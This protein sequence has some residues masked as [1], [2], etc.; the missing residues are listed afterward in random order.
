M[1]NLCSLCVLSCAY[2]LQKNL[3][4]FLCTDYA[5]SSR[6]SKKLKVKHSFKEYD[7]STEILLLSEL[8]N[9]CK[10]VFKIEVLTS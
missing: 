6:V 2:F 8:L 4:V 1:L 10:T 3:L 9:L 5:E 7:E